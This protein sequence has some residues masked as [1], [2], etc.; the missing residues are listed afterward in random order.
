M[1]LTLDRMRADVARLIELEPE[2]I[3]DDDNLVDLGLDSMRL[4]QLAMGWEQAGLRVDFG[5][6]AE[7]S[8]LGDWWREIAAPQAG[9]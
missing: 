6:L 3:K 8:T 9:T 2:E 1:T 7:Y 5:I 4:M